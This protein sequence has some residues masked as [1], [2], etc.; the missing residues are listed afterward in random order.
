MPKSPH[1]PPPDEVVEP[2]TM[3]E[4]EE[5]V[6][7]ALK[8]DPKGISGKHREKPPTEAQDD[9]WENEGGSTE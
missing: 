3:D 4:V 9:D 2:L 7:A 1:D 5:R 8:V 6:A